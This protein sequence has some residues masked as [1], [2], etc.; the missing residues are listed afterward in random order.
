MSRFPSL[1]L[2]LL[3]LAALTILCVGT[4]APRIQANVLECTQTGLQQAGLVGLVTV[5]DGRDVALSGPGALSSVEDQARQ[6]ALGCGARVVGG[7][8]GAVPTGPYTTSFCLE[9][10]R[11]SLAGSVPDATSGSAVRTG[12]AARLGSPSFVGDLSVR[13]DPPAGYAGML[14]RSALE[15][16]QLDEGCIEI[17]DDEVRVSGEVRSQAALDGL[18]ERFEASAGDDFRVS[19]D[20][21][22]PDLSERALACQAAYNEMFGAGARV[23]FDFDSSELH[24]EGRAL[25]DTVEGIWAEQCPDVSILVTG[26]TDNVGEPA[27]N[28]TLSLER[29]QAVVAYLIQQGFDPAKLTALGYGETQ[30]RADNDTEEGRTQ[31][32]RIEFRI[33]E[34]EQ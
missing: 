24:Q 13:P 20:L 23:L 18:M 34:T 16:P 29:A 25:L 26:H 31:N 4:G 21:E 33:R 2:G 7:A 1:I 10:G 14:E 5:V 3:A 9:P 8:W 15:L 6:I 11:V 30:P 32:R 17:A 19:F 27:Y 22:V 12:L 28:R